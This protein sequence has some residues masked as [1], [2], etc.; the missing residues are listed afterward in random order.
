MLYKHGAT[1]KLLGSDSGSTNE[2]STT[3]IC[4]CIRC[5]ISIRTAVPR[6]QFNVGDYFFAIAIGAN[7]LNSQMREIGQLEARR[8]RESIWLDSSIKFTIMTHSR[9]FMTFAIEWCLVIK[10]SSS[11]EHTHTHPEPDD[12]CRNKSTFIEQIQCKYFWSVA[13]VKLAWTVSENS[14]LCYEKRSKSFR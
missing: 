2:T 5:T 8:T 13:A 1:S 3:G 9:Y 14:K 10:Q 7:F 11:R 12:G 4:K 6:I